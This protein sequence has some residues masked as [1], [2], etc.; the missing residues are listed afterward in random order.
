M[1][2]GRFG[3]ETECP[4]SVGTSSDSIPPTAFAAGLSL[5]DGAEGGTPST[6]P[7][8]PNRLLVHPDLSVTD[9]GSMQMGV[10][11]EDENWNDER[12]NA[13][14][15][16]LTLTAMMGICRTFIGKVRPSKSLYLSQQ[17]LRR[18]VFHQREPEP[19]LPEVLDGRSDEIDSVVDNHKPVM[20]L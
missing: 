17:F 2:Y 6:P 11:A 3:E 20:C 5:C 12:G 4:G 16:W 10:M 13:G 18:S 1:V 14:K 7:P 19:F 9:S 8:S 15:P